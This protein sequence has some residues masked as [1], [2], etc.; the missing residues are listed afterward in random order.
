MSRSDLSPIEFGGIGTLTNKGVSAR[1]L[2]ELAEHKK[3]AT[4]SVIL[5]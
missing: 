4:R 2:M 1:V 3:L 5:M